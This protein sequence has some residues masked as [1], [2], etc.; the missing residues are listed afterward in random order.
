MQIVPEHPTSCDVVVITLSGWWGDSCIPNYSAISRVGNNIYF[1]VIWDYPPNIMC[2]AVITPWELTESIGPLPTGTYTVYAGLNG[3]P[4]IP[5]GYTPVA[6][7]I[8]TDKQF[9]LSTGSLM[10]PEGETATFTVR[11]L[12]DPGETVEV[13]VARESGDPDITVES[14]ALLIFDPCNYSIPQTVTLAAAEDE[15]LRQARS[16]ASLRSASEG[17]LSAHLSS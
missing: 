9:V 4:F 7:F 16:H 5:P 12:M 8:V 1:D 13:T 6:E 14:G 17:R 3:Y 11:L 10:V 2:L 15:L